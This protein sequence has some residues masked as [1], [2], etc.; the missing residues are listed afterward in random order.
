M[1]GNGYFQTAWLKRNP[2]P[3]P[4]LGQSLVRIAGIDA[5]TLHG[6]LCFDR[7][8][9]EPA[10]TRLRKF[11]LEQSTAHQPGQPKTLS[12]GLKEQPSNRPEVSSQSSNIRSVRQL[13]AERL[14]VPVEALPQLT[15]GDVMRI[16]DV[17]IPTLHGWVYQ[18]RELP[19]AAI[20][21]LEQFFAAK[22]DLA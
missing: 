1:A 4:V 19:A 11:F 8:F 5:N 22:L 21:K 10:I 15:N 12:K 6:F 14:K 3:I 18:R 17:D 13:F 16:A 2:A 9:P 7:D 20:E